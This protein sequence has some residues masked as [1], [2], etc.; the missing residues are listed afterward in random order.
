M[1]RYTYII[2]ALFVLTVL[3]GCEKALGLEEP[4]SDPASVYEEAWN[5]IDQR[6]ALFTVKGVD[7][8]TIHDKYSAAIN[9]KTTQEELFHTIDNM[10]ETLQDGHVTL[11]SPF[12]T[13]TYLGFYELF[14]KNF[15]YNNLINTYLQNDY[16]RIGPVIYKI[17]NNTGYV[18][19]ASFGNDISDAQTDSLFQALKDTKGLIIDVRNNTGGKPANA[20]KIFQHLLPAKQLVRYEVLKKGIGHEDLDNPSPYYLS[21]AG[22]LYRNPVCLLTNRSCYSTCNDFVLYM[23]SLPN[24][25][26][27]G[28][29]TGGGGSIPQVYLLRNGWKLQYSSS[30]TLSPEKKPTENGIQPDLPIGIS[31]LDEGRG[32]DSIVENAYRILQ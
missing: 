30:M 4:A 12:D 28:D 13:A 8:K 32:I 2:P 22:S 3:S 6:Y 26:I 5:V 23:S 14:P 16:H 17:Q 24:V 10:L 18:Y 1:F 9:G 15:N 20:E 19:Y 7:W 31:G 25:K 27:I 29:Q 21:P 11:M